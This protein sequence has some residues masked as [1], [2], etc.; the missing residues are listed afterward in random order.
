V[1]YKQ[2]R[3]L[4]REILKKYNVSEAGIEIAHLL[5]SFMLKRRE[6]IDKLEKQKGLRLNDIVGSL[7]S[8]IDFHGP[9]TKENLESASKRIYGSLLLEMR[10]LILID[11]LK[12]ENEW[13]R[14]RA[15]DCGQFYAAV[16]IDTDWGIAANEMVE[17]ALGGRFPELTLPKSHKELQAC[18]NCREN[19]PE[20]LREKMSEVIA[21]FEKR[22]DA[23][24]KAPFDLME[25]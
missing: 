3:F 15:R 2:L 13:L 11:Q 22:L 4:I 23:C 20:H 9:I 25:D 16:G 10:E 5:D 7:K 12:E 19:A 21:Y 6:N 24:E 8:T 17:Y 1:K 18:L 14:K